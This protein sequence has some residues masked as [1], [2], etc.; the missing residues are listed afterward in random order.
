MSYSSW[1]HGIDYKWINN[2]II[3]ILNPKVTTKIQ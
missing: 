3:M 1:N 2:Y